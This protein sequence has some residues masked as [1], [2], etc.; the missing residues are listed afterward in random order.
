M[1]EPINPEMAQISFLDKE[2]EEIVQSQLDVIAD[3]LLN[4]W[5]QSNQDEGVFW[6]DYQIALMCDSDYLKGKFNQ[7]YN[8]KP[9]D[10]EYLEVGEDK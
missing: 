4:D 3:Q 6:S 9:E 8:L 2:N 7:F 1:S 5:L 10:S